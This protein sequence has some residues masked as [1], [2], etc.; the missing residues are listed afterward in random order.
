MERV[1]GKS[2]THGTI[3]MHPSTLTAG[4]SPSNT[5]PTGTSASGKPPA[6]TTA[7]AKD[8]VT[9]T[10]RHAQETKQIDAY[11][12]GDGQATDHVRCI[13]TNIS[14]TPYRLVIPKFECFSPRENGINVKGMSQNMMFMGTAMA[15]E[16]PLE[17]AKSLDTVTE[18]KKRC[19]D[20]VVKV[21][22][23]KTADFMILTNC[24]STKTV[25]P[26]PSEVKGKNP[27][28]AAGPYSD[29][30]TWRRLAAITQVCEE[31]AR[32][33][34]YSTL[35][36]KNAQKQL[37]QLTLWRQLGIASGDADDAVSTES[38]EHDVMKQLSEQADKDPS[39][40]NK[41]QEM[42]YQLTPES[43]IA[44]ELLKIAK[45]DGA[46]QQK[47]KSIGYDASGS[48]GLPDTVTELVHKAQA[49]PQLR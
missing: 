49:D 36:L 24:I 13:I 5:S 27:E 8:W 30:A 21:A 3:T 18:F 17:G 44:K 47:L 39:L 25:V 38:I 23:G 15:V 7:G 43:E 6:A 32:S 22:P 35:P 34:A 20:A 33:G 1:E 29:T 14:N 26:P 42:G 37:T 12:K 9:D 10:V 41:L 19:D 11:L 31:L 16:V 48:K 45:K 46:F 40:K 2:T 28:Y 4:T